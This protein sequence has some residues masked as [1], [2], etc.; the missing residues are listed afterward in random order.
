MAYTTKKVI[1]GTLITI[2]AIVGIGY[3]AFR[4]SPWPAALLI[5][6]AFNSEAVKV[7]K[8]L[9]KFVPENIRSF[10]N[11]QFDLTDKDAFLDSYFPG[12]GSSKSK[13]PVIVWIHGGGLISGS[14]DQIANYCKILSSKG[15]VAITIDYTIAPEGKYPTP[16]R[17][18][19]KALKYISENSDK[20]NADTSFIILA[21]DSGGS[22]IAAQVANIIYNQE[23]AEFTKVQPGIASRQLK[24]LLLYCGIYDISNIKTEGQFGYFMQTVLWSYFGKKDIS[25]DR[26]AN[27]ASVFEHIGKR[28]PPSFISAGNGDPLLSQS[29][30]LSRKLTNMGFEVDSLFFPDN[31]QPPLP[32]EYQFALDTRAGQLAL[33]RSLVFLNNLTADQ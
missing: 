7:N 31:M 18:V 24:G 32:H 25:D 5:R 2:L 12:P 15:F 28:F 29:L 3:L 22:M 21:G 10:E 11:L 26:Y 20:L 4:I 13:Y 17:Q 33:E 1:T 23:Y 8:R 30:T 6:Q 16:L 19:N 14:R 27:S 9:E